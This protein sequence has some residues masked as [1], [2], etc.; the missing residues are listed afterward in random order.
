MIRD[1]AYHIISLLACPYT[2]Y[3]YMAQS[4]Q[5][6]RDTE[7]WRR[8][9]WSRFGLNLQ[10]FEVKIANMSREFNIYFGEYTDI[11]RLTYIVANL[12]KGTVIVINNKEMKNWKAYLTSLNTATL[13][14]YDKKAPEKS[15]VSITDNAE[16]IVLMNMAQY[17][18]L[19]KTKYKCY[20]SYDIDMG[21]D[22]T[23]SLRTVNNDYPTNT[24]RLQKFSLGKLANI[25]ITNHLLRDIN[26]QFNNAYIASTIDLPDIKILTIDDDLICNT[27]DYSCKM[28]NDSAYMSRKKIPHADIV[29]VGDND[30]EYKRFKANL[31]NMRFNCEHNIN[32]HLVFIHKAKY[33]KHRFEELIP[34]KRCADVITTLRLFNIDAENLTDNDIL[35]IFNNN[36]KYIRAHAT[37][38]NSIIPARLNQ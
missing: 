35:M 23:I 15:R 2:Q 27:F 38:V 5:M 10:P 26:Q 32:L 34:Y 3:S 28:V 12:N 36:R 1:I 13:T 22:S 37:D 30:R 14:V 33:I 18:R 4:A 25:T 21:F 31:D 17:K 16:K 20:I 11:M 9:N 19:D 8:A 24:I 7:D 29:Y 6:W